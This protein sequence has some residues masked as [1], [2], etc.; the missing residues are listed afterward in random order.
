[1]L[2]CAVPEAFVGDSMA[3]GMQADGAVVAILPFYTF[4]YTWVPGLAQADTEGFKERQG[5]FLAESTMQLAPAPAQS[6]SLQPW[7]LLSVV[8]LQRA[9]AAGAQAEIAVIATDLLTGERW[10]WWTDLAFDPACT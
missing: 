10:A 5:C 2:S 1:M 4:N 6:G 3:I 8:N 9:Y 7:T